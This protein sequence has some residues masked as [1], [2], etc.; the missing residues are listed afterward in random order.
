MRARLGLAMRRSMNFGALGDVEYLMQGEGL[1]MAPISTG[2]ATL[3]VGGITVLPTATLDD[4]TR[5]QVAAL[6]V[7]GGV[8]DADSEVKTA[9]LVAAARAR[10]MP[11]LAFGEG[12]VQAAR[13][14]DIDPAKLTEAP[15]VE[16]RDGQV[17]AILDRDQLSAA[18]A[19]IG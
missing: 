5:G 13:A 2:D 3:S 18:A 4:V 7:P 17:T 8:S 11:V 10:G 6:I 14:F 15:G 19:R 12:V 9:E 1:S 16:F